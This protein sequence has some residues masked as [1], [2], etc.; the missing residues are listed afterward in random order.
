MNLVKQ[1]PQALPLLSISEAAEE[2]RNRLALAARTVTAIT[3]NASN[4][5]ARNAAV[6]IREH[7]KEVEAERTRL[8]K[9]LL[10][11]Q[12]TLKALADDYCSCL[13][14]ELSRLERLAATFLEAEK[15]RVAREQ[16]DQDAKLASLLQEQ[17]TLAAAAAVAANGV[18]TEEQLAAAIEIEAKARETAV[19]VQTAVAQPL[20]REER[21]RGQSSRQVMEYTIT[22]LESLRKAKPDCVRLVESRAMIQELCCPGDG[23][24][25]ITCWYV[26][27]A[28]FSTR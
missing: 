22:D 14:D 17:A 19:A 7:L 3:D 13:Q 26:N 12:R 4:L 25:G 9:P 16:A 23:T 21:A 11:G 28:T 20:P 10:A 5:A 6:S 27:K 1:E 15:A 2:F 8:T 18:Q 24:P